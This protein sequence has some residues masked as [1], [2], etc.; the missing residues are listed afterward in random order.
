MVRLDHTLQVL[1]RLVRETAGRLGR[2]VALDLQGGGTQADKRIADGL[3][4][5]LLHT[6]R[7]AIDH[8]IEPPSSRTLAGKPAEGSLVVHARQSGD[9]LVIDV[10]DDG[11]GIDPA[12]IR[13]AAVARGLIGAEAASSLDEAAAVDLLFTPGFSTASS[14]SAVSGRGVGLDA[15][16]TSIAALGGRVE[17]LSR[18]GAGTTVRFT[19]P[20]TAVLTTLVQV[21]VGGEV[22]G[23]PIDRVAELLHLPAAGISVLADGA[24]FDLRG[25][26][27]PLLMLAR[28]LGLPAPARGGQVARVVVVRCG[29]ELVGFE[30]DGFGERFDAVVRPSHGLLAGMPGLLG[31]VLLGDGTIMLVLDLAALV[32]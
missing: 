24:A 2:A 28:L 11:A 22:F 15:V 30:V 32:P 14:V 7:N 29:A 31:N 20:Q 12:A 25:G 21:A 8:G 5:P 17:I 1:P 23:I 26:T 19:I 4:E 3:F 13:D 18:L 10:T 16:R 6:V 27:V 9:R